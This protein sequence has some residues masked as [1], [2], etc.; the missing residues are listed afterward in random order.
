MNH[1]LYKI[2]SKINEWSI[3]AIVKSNSNKLM[4]SSN[5]VESIDKLINAGY[6]PV[7]CAMLNLTKVDFILLMN[8]LNEKSTHRVDIRVKNDT[9]K[10]F[11]CDVMLN[12][13][14]QY[15]NFEI[16][17][18]VTNEDMQTNRF[19][20]W[21]YSNKTSINSDYRVIINSGFKGY[22]V[23]QLDVNII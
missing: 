14:I 8:E 17:K 18:K 23:L 6:S 4:N 5:I 20:I 9:Y 21:E 11:L 10:E 13:N 19:G 2:H 1:Q 7:E 15:D 16:N 3:D 22:S 12:S